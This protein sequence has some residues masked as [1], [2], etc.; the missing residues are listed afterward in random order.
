VSDWGPWLAGRERLGAL[1][2]PAGICGSRAFVD[3]LFKALISTSSAC[4]LVQFDCPRLRSALAW[5]STLGCGVAQPVLANVA[6][7]RCGELGSLGC[8][9]LRSE[10]VCSRGAGTQR[11]SLWR[12][13]E[14][15]ACKC[16]VL[17][18]PLVCRSSSTALGR[19]PLGGIAPG[20]GV[21][22]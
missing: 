4:C 1:G 8:C 12:I 3:Y 10:L 21:L 18:L 17:R 22:R 7:S 15:C 11:D 19:G 9:S 14:R 5:W 6:L 16:A 2:S 13:A 20:S